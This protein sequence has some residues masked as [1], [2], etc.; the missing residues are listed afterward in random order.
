[1]D[2]ENIVLS[3]VNQI[4]TNATCSPYMCILIK[5]SLSIVYLIM[6]SSKSQKRKRPVE[7]KGWEGNRGQQSTSDVKLNGKHQGQKELRER[8][9]RE[10]GKQQRRE[11]QPTLVRGYIKR[12][13]SEH[14]NILLS[15]LLL[16]H[17]NLMVNCTG[18]D[19][20]RFGYGAQRN[21]IVGKLVPSHGLAFILPEELHRLLGNKSHYQSYLAVN[22][23]GCRHDLPGMTGIL[24]LQGQ[25]WYGS[26]QLL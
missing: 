10:D 6:S 18:E 23:E 3:E 21:E 12:I 15:F 25:H 4:Q 8:Q 24:V 13:K 7:D 5:R 14:M 26:D 1:M 11:G 20:V 2:L 22:P 17:Q 19:N 9:V 16:S